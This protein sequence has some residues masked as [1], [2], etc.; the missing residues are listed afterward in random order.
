LADPGFRADCDAGLDSSLEASAFASAV[1]FELARSE[2]ARVSISFA[3]ADVIS[4]WSKA[5]SASP[6]NKHSPNLF[7]LSATLRLS[8][9]KD[10]G[11]IRPTLSR[12][13]VSVPRDDGRLADRGLPDGALADRHLADGSLLINR[14][15]VREVCGGG[16]GYQRKRRARYDH[17]FHQGNSPFRLEKTRQ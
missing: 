15:C 8:T 14:L 2:P 9:V 13:G 3:E 4:H 7:G 16:G 11:R 17:K 10:E 1:R 5:A 12:Y 6:A